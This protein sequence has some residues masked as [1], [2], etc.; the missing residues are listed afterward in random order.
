MVKKKIRK[1]RGFVAVKYATTSPFYPSI[2]CLLSLFSSLLS[3]RV[4]N[5]T[6]KRYRQIVHSFVIL[7]DRLNLSLSFISNLPL[8]RTSTLRNVCSSIILFRPL[9]TYNKKQNLAS[10][11]VFCAVLSLS[12]D[13]R[14][15][16]NPFLCCSLS[17]CCAALEVHAA[18]CF[19]L[20]FVKYF[21]VPVN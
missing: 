13:I 4:I 15:A 7:C 20:C 8:S 21:F 16:H 2:P 18:L 10:T 19:P 5:Y 6:Q 12:A 1:Q 9:I 3:H 14:S 11:S 17:L